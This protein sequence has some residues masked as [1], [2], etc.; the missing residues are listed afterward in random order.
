LASSTHSGRIIL[1]GAFLFTA[2]EGDLLRST[3]DLDLHAEEED[4]GEAARLLREV[5]ALASP[6]PD[7]VEFEP[8]AARERQLVGS[9]L[10]GLRLTVPARVG[11]A[12]PQLKID[13]G[14]GHPIRPGPE[15]RQYPTLLPG[16][17]AFTVRTYPRETVIAEKLA[18]AVEFG[19]DNTRIRDY[20][21][22]W[23]LSGRYSY[24]GHVLFDAV[25]S[26][27]R[28]RDAGRFLTRRDDYWEGAF[29]TDF[30]ARRTER[31][32]KNWVADHAPH[33]S[34]PTFCQTVLEVNRFAL[35]LLRA[36]R[37]GKRFNARW[38]PA[39]GWSLR[40]S[41]P[42]KIIDSHRSL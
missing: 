36:A 7:G 40:S 17:A 30:M 8:S 29:N 3:A 6:T 19:R 23:Y 39:V 42:N 4:V 38:N 18:A 35:P 37:D 34:P 14:F 9:R 31:S 26:T 27:F 24:F 25:L 16:F 20:Y 12:M 1:K 11:G 21:D 2:W 22:L 10:P 32:W 13:V 5:A 33:A 28:E 41:M 15:T